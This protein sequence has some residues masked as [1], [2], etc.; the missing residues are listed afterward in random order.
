MVTVVLF[1]ML[2]ANVDDDE[3]LCRAYAAAHANETWR[4]PSGV[5][6]YPYL[7]PAGPYEQE[8]DWDSVFLGTGTLRWGSRNY[9][10]G[11]MRNFFVATNLSDGSVTGCLTP[12]TPTIC[13]SDP[14]LTEGEFRSV[15]LSTLNSEPALRSGRERFLISSALILWTKSQPTRAGRFF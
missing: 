2:L 15:R 11:S 7:V 12:T 4:Q 13:S 1:N 8:W 5:L 6:Q 3:T 14:H 10:D 9:L